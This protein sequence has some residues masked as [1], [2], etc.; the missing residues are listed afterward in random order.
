MPVSSK[1][2]R[3]FNVTSLI[4]LHLLIVLPLAYFLNIWADEASTLYTTQHGFM[5]AFQHAAVNEKQVPLYFWIMSLWRL[6]NDS[7]FFARLFSII[8]SL[9]AIKIFAGLA[10]RFLPSRAAV[11]TTGFFAFHPFLIWA[12]LEIRVYSLVILLSVLLMRLF[13]DGFFEEGH[14]KTRETQT[15]IRILFLL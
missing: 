5:T 6:I 3:E 11:L 9:A 13:F 1:N 15:K 2:S 12:S 8:C 14:A 4:F 10:S 7:I